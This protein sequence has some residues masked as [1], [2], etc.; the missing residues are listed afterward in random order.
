MMTD[1]SDDEKVSSGQSPPRTTADFGGRRKIFE[2]RMHR[3]P[4]DHPDR[5]SGKDPRSGFDRRN[6]SDDQ[7]EDSP[8][9]RALPP[10]PPDQD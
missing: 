7:T 1:S 10:P 5:R 6:L 2:R 8:E 4:F 3:A 9:R